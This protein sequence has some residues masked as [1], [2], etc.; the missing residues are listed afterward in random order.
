MPAGPSELLPESHA[1]A[2]ST[3]PKLE[4]ETSSNLVLESGRVMVGKLSGQ[5][6]CARGYVPTKVVTV[7]LRSAAMKLV[8]VTGSQRPI[9]AADCVRTSSATMNGAESRVGSLFLQQ[10]PLC[11]A[12]RVEL[13][14]KRALWRLSSAALPEKR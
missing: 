3:K 6:V 13:V 9:R 10:A 14:L 12:S 2:A 11:G 8:P 5:R 7:L 1:T 4:I